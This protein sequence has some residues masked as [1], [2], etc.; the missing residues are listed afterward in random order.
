MFLMKKNMRFSIE[1]IFV[2]RFWVYRTMGGAI[3]FPSF[4]GL[5]LDYSPLLEGSLAAEL[6]VGTSR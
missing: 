2:V 6:M 5:D 4:K 1:F 3:A